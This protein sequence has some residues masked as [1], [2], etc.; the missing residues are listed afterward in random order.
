MVSAISS[1]RSLI[2]SGS[3]NGDGVVNAASSQTNRVRLK[4]DA[5]PFLPDAGSITRAAM[6]RSRVARQ[7][8]MGVMAAP[9]RRRGLMVG[10]TAVNRR[11]SMI[12]RRNV[13][14]LYRGVYAG[15][16]FKGDKPADLPVQQSIK[17]EPVINLK[18]AKALGLTIPE[19]LLATADEAIQ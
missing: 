3:H 19:T 1:S 7:A 11:A 15:R 13:E 9:C 8:G 5:S 10:Q 2:R 17:V 6:Q 16:I 4:C 14:I 12:D 18:T